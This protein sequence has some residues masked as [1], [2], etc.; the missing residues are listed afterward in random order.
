MDAHILK[1]LCP[2]EFFKW[3]LEICKIPH[4]SGNEKQ[5]V[6]FLVSFAEQRAI[7]YSVDEKGN[8]FM[9]LPASWGYE[10][11]PSVL[12]QAHLDMVCVKDEDLIFNFE[13]DSLK[14]NVKDGK[15]SAIGTSLGADNGVGVATMLAIADSNELNHPALELL[16]TVEEEIGLVGIRNFDMSKIKSRRMINM[17]CGDSHVIAVSSFGKYAADV[18]KEFNTETLDDTYSFFK[19]SLFGGIG[20]HAGLMA[21][22]GRCCM[23]NAMGLV[24]EALK[25]FSIRLVSLES[26]NVAILS[27]CTAVIALPKKNA[28]KA[29][30][31]AENCFKQLYSLYEKT[32]PDIKISICETELCENALTVTDTLVVI[33]Y[34]NLIKTMPYRIDGFDSSIIITI[35]TMQKFILS[36]GRFVGRFSVS[37][38]NEFDMKSLYDYYVKQIKKLGFKAKLYDYYPGWKE[39][40]DSEFREKFI[41]K[42]KSLFGTKP[43]IERVPG[44][45]EVAVITSEIPDMDA[46]GIAPTARGAHTTNE[47]IILSEVPDYWKLLLAVLEEKE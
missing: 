44:G 19:I 29:I 13:T 26:S 30:I 39:N 20:G 17:D 34:L 45:I 4:G 22:K 12:L 43:Q 1:E 6:E 9:Q 37:S 24:F 10:N 16:F 47:H 18:I 5:L 15:L 3:F 38:S 33:D 41:S 23:G 27:E 42:H 40:S 36:N 35:S 32:D 8:V 11:E 25:E 21:S 31:E 28:Q 2:K 46:V 14:L 7:E